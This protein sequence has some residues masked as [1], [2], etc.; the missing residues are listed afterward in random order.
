MLHNVG[1]LVL[2]TFKDIE[3]VFNKAGV[4][5]AGIDIMAPNAMLRVVKIE[6]LDV[7]QANILKQEMSVCGGEV[8]ISKTVRG[9]TNAILMGTIVQLNRVRE[10]LTSQPFGLKGI[11]KEIGEVLKNFDM[12]PHI[13]KAGK[14]ELDLSERTHVMGILNATPDSFYDGGSYL[15]IS[16]A[17]SHG[18]SMFEDGADIIDV[19]G[20]SSRPGAKP[21]SLEEELKKVIP[22][23]EELTSKVD[24]PISIDTYKAKVAKRALE[25]GATIINDI[26]GLR[27]DKDMP[28]LVATAGAPVI[29][30]HMQGAPQIMQDNPHYDCLIGEIISFL[31][32]QAEVALKAGVQ[33]D[34]IIIDPG[35]GFG[36]T[37]EHNL[38]IARRLS[39]LKSLGYPILMGTSRKSFIGETLDLPV[40]ERI[41]GTAATVAYSIT[42][43]ANIVRV[44][45][46]RE[47]VRV[48]R[49][50]DAMVRG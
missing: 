47:M 15:E 2:K 3:K 31:R 34:K 50:T 6:G 20:E 41:E 38:E 7:C 29:I 14:S 9:F 32:E 30:M 33:E 8:A 46:V 19:G 40:E 1:I 4:D 5:P 24:C 12:K 36:K 16:A 44:H 18:V 13:I 11:S 39:E 26:S 42:Q 49:M 48:A 17:I 10:R 35:I 28:K 43:G 25:A 45:D 22:I 21:V 37:R 27:V 23:I